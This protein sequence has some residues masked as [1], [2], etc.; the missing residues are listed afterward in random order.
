MLL[1]Q[2]Y[3][4]VYHKKLGFKQDRILGID[5][6]R[7]T[8]TVIK[9]KGATKQVIFNSIAFYFE[10]YCVLMTRPRET[11]RERERF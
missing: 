3:N 2:T 5:G 11:E 8:Y 1:F 7:I 4:V 9:K 6:E 10:L